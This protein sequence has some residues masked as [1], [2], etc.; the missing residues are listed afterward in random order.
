MDTKSFAIYA[1]KLES[2]LKNNRALRE[3]LIVDQAL[4]SQPVSCE[5]ATATRKNFHLRIPCT[6][7]LISKIFQ[8]FSEQSMFW[9]KTRFMMMV[10]MKS[11]CGM[12]NQRKNVDLFFSRE[13][14]RMFITL[15][16]SEKQRVG[17][18]NLQNLNSAFVEW[19]YAAVIST[20]LRRLID[21]FLLPTR[22]CKV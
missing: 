10:I 19:T 9:E 21:S 12:V 14:C 3:I 16:T 5:Y 20:T 1:L 22:S 7:G 8:T 6:N 2:N 4:L 13:H 11:H 17:F 18:E 15:Q